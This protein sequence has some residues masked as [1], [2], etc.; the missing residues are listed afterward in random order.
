MLS[1]C[2]GNVRLRSDREMCSVP[3]A[4]PNQWIPCLLCAPSR[5]ETTDV[6]DVRP[7]TLPECFRNGRSLR[8]RSECQKF[9]CGSTGMYKEVCICTSYRRQVAICH[10]I[11]HHLLTSPEYSSVLK[12][13]SSY[14]SLLQ[15]LQIPLYTNSVSTPTHP[16]THTRPH[17]PL[18]C[19]H[20]SKWFTPCW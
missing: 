16:Q 9:G 7:P 15:L 20:F 19:P 1:S 14:L 11:V 13:V 4:W 10:T 18:K 5:G 6:S 8:D 12:Q 3:N 17:S 2:T